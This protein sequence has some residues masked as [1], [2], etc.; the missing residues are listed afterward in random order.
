MA[1]WMDG[2]LP[3]FDSIRF[4]SSPGGGDINGLCFTIDFIFKNET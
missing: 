3:G 2:W 1:G 4:V